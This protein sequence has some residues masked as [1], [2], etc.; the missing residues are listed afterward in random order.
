MFLCLKSRFVFFG[1][2]VEDEPRSGQLIFF[3]LLKLKINILNYNLMWHATINFL[4]LF[5]SSVSLPVRLVTKGS[6]KNLNGTRKLI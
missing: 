4:L 6:F 2:L 3:L 5:Y 1:V